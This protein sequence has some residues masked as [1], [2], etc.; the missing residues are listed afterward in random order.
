MLAADR[1]IRRSLHA[2]DAQYR[3]SA[4][5]ATSSATKKAASSRTVTTG[6]TNEGRAATRTATAVQAL[7]TAQARVLAT[8]N[9]VATSA[10]RTA[11]AYDREAAA[12]RRLAAAERSRAGVVR[13][14]PGGAGLIGRAARTTG[15][16]GALGAGVALGQVVQ[17][18]RAMRNVNS[19]AQVGEKRFQRLSTAVREL[20]G[21]TAQMPRTLAEGLYDLV[22]SGFNARE[23]MHILNKSAR[24]ATAGLTT[25]EVSTKA[26]SAV[27]N[28]YD[29]SARNAGRVSDVLFRT[30]DRGQISFEELAQNIG[31]VLPWGRTLGVTLE[32]LGAAV[33]T[34]TV[35]TGGQAEDN[36]TRLR[37]ALVALVKPSEALKAAYDELGVRSG[38]ELIKSSGSLQSALQ[39]LYGTTGGNVEAFQQLFPDIRG[40]AGALL[41][42]GKNAKDAGV[43]LESLRHSQ[44]ATALALSQQSKSIALQWDRLKAKASN[45]A[46]SLGSELVPET[47]R[48][49]RILTNPNLGAGDKFAMVVDRMA[50]HLSAAIPR[51]AEAAAAAAPEVA[52][53]F[54]TGFVNSN[55]W[56]RLAIGTFL[57]AKLGGFK[58]ARGLGAMIGG[59]VATGM[60]GGAAGGAVAGGAGGGLLGG[61]LGKGGKLAKVGRVGA[62]GTG[63]ALADT[64][65][66]EF[67]RRADERG[68]DI[69]KALDAKAEGSV[70]DRAFQR[71]KFGD[72]MVGDAQAGAGAAEDLKDALA[73]VAEK[74]AAIDPKNL[75]RYRN[76]LEDLALESEVARKEATKL[77][78]VGAGR[79]A[80]LT[81]IR[82]E[83]G[84]LSTGAIKDVKGMR[85]A[86]ADN[87]AA[88]K[89]RFGFDTRQGREL[90]RENFSAARQWIEISMRD[91]RDL[92]EKGAKA[93][94]WLLD[95]HTR[96]GANAV[97]K[98]FADVGDSIAKEFDQA[99]KS[100][101]QSIDAI[102]RKVNQPPRLPRTLLDW[103][104]PDGQRRGGRVSFRGG[105]MVPVAASPG[106]AMRFP[107]GSWAGIPGD[108]V[109]ADNVFMSVP[110]G[111]EFYT[112]HG[113]S[114]LA[115][116]ASRAT[117][118]AAQMPH[119]R[120]G[121]KVKVKTRLPQW[122]KVYP[123]HSLSAVQRN[124]KAYFRFTRGQVQA[125][126]EDAGWSPS[127]AG[128]WTQITGGESMRYPGIVASD[129]GIGLG[130]ITP[131]AAFPNHNT[132][133]Y[134]TFVRLGGA[135]GM[136]NPI[137]N[138]RMSKLMYDTAGGWSP[139]H[140]T[141]YLTAARQRESKLD[142]FAR[143]EGD[144]KTV[145]VK[146]P[147]RPEEPGIPARK[148]D[149]W[150]RREMLTGLTGGSFRTGFDAGLSG[151]QRLLG[152]SGLRDLIGASA[153]AGSRPTRQ[154][155]VPTNIRKPQGSGATATGIAPGGGYMGTERIV[156]QASRGFANSYKRPYDTV[157]GA[158]MSDHYTGKK[159]AYAADCDPGDRV[160]NAIKRRLG[161]PH[162][163]GTYTRYN[164]PG[165]KGYNAQLLWR[166]ANHNWGDNPHV[167][168][169]VQKLRR[170][171]IAGRFQRGGSVPGEREPDWLREQIRARGRPFARRLR[172]QV[173]LIESAASKA[174]DRVEELLHSF[175][176]GLDNVARIS[177]ARL[178][179]TRT[180]IRRQISDLQKGGVTRRE[181]AQIQR[182]R[183]SIDLVEAEMGRRTGLLVAHQQ[184]LATS[185][186]RA[187]TRLDQRMR[188][189]NIAGDSVAGLAMLAAFQRKTADNLRAQRNDLQKA[190]QKARRAGDRD[191]AREI[192]EALA[193]NLLAIGEAQVSRIE[194]QR[195]SIAAAANKR[196]G[197]TEFTLQVQQGYLAALDARQ[198]LLRTADTPEGM[199]ARA[200]G[201][202]QGVVPAIAAQRDAAYGQFI[203]LSK[204]GDVAG[205]RQAWLSAQSSA[206]D[207]ANAMATAADL[208]R[209][210]SLRASQDLVDTATHGKTMADFGLQRIE[211]EQRIAGTFE[212]GGAARADY[213]RETIM[214]ALEAE[215]AALQKQRTDALVQGDPVL[216]RQIAEAIAGKQNDILQV[217]ATSNEEI[218]DNTDP[219]NLAGALAFEA[220]GQG[221][222]DLVSAGVGI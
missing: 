79:H 200:A 150:T 82:L 180:F 4:A 160:F 137:R 171:G 115:S 144:W 172:R 54:V 214:P 61:I 169:G 190:L 97:R 27:L 91:G 37:G 220:G 83:F 215:L 42:T 146:G 186:E 208:F 59:G 2:T 205:A 173:G 21:R 107:D 48:L 28:S 12:A 120:E 156:K 57:F 50:D 20:G 206:N 131:W 40:A 65:L 134:R 68:D 176:G 123:A 189:E 88:I 185:I 86:V 126:G 164:I 138:A 64:V 119:F 177:Y 45:L 87:L 34:M 114:L 130:Q 199:R 1:Q 81:D 162:Q 76:A 51:L 125:I 46:I 140:G 101:G 141:R 174:N 179:R 90:V 84:K 13:G 9:Q 127:K 89:K 136:R 158:D 198:R 175:A 66:N 163:P 85:A 36:M 135:S 202:K 98:N 211:L 30:V 213:M 35:K 62:I 221:F 165:L 7:N 166:V 181:G 104:N 5:V 55:S 103:I 63:I 187:S 212:T 154:T 96:R 152:V 56:G 183:A 33:S 207:L 109:A 52:G 148:M 194:L 145:T 3:K 197:D 203:A 118:L 29:M 92:T 14:P 32:E 110:T 222:T 70:F 6:L 168:L 41:L 18:D 218:K 8:T 19:I 153:I 99:A 196:V 201:I 209:D 178:L 149:R 15:L 105:G 95:H 77:L 193:E 151:T 10:T 23:S 78:N 80:K 216:A 204:I 72:A 192:T 58:A 157:E 93:M 11:G 73:G 217:I 16:G 116:G 184:R 182:L 38:P 129:N 25:T 210:A 94:A 31:G 17:F 39:K 133:L 71:L 159:N 219:K 117:A 161:T 67:S 121:G 155:R 106:E 49:L 74:G 100:V 132:E 139:W 47:R 53:A 24:A 43:D 122:D 124:P 143:R 170:G 69:W 112:D 26:V 195:Q 75:R 111:T 128:Q 188:R 102:I 44:G 113:Q 60:A 142:K 167:H 108:R 191:T 22:S 147:W